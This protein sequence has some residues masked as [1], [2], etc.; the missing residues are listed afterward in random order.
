V[1]RDFFERLWHLHAV[2]LYDVGKPSLEQNVDAAAK[3]IMEHALMAWAATR[4]MVYRLCCK[5]W[6]AAESAAISC[7]RL[8]APT[9]LT[10]AETA[11][12]HQLNGRRCAYCA[13]VLMAPGRLPSRRARAATVALPPASRR[14]LRRASTQA[15]SS[16]RRTGSFS[17]GT[18]AEA[19]PSGNTG[20]GISPV[21][22]R[23]S[24]GW[25]TP[26][27]RPDSTS[28]GRVRGP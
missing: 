15:R 4:V 22:R 1:G 27:T 21:T 11:V 3:A 13:S 6:A 16:S 8:Q 24:C 12:L 9:V 25:S 10:H 5:R 23:Q 19:P 14:S 2:R 7:P 20:P 28:R 26:P 17:Y 18:L